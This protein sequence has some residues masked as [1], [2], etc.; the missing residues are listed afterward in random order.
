MKKRVRY[1]SFLVEIVQIFRLGYK[2]FDIFLCWFQISVKSRRYILLISGLLEPCYYIGPSWYYYI[3]S[4]IN[5][6]SA[7]Y[8]N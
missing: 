5:V 2:S 6:L 7:L 3:H 1:A 4:A 8:C